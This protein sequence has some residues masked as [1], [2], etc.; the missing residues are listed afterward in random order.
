[1]WEKWEEEFRNDPEFIY[2]LLKEHLA[3]QLKKLM[4]EKGLNKKEL[5][6]RMGVSPSY[7]TKIF[8]GDNISLKTIAKVLAA[9]GEENLSLHL[10]PG[11][12]TDRYRKLGELK[13]VFSEDFK[14][15]LEA[16]ND[17]ETLALAA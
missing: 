4:E 16:T 15:D 8:G 5:A 11:Y 14:A 12:D 3:L 9:L 7:I 6:R 2:E 10:L 1:M 13:I 17:G